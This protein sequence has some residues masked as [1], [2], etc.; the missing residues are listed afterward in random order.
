M[1]GSFNS[2]HKYFIREN[3]NKPL[4]KFLTKRVKDRLLYL[5]LP[6][7][8]AE[9]I[10]QWI[11]YVK[12]VIAFQ[13]REYGEASDEEQERKGIEE[14]NSLLQQLEREKQIDNYVVYDGYL[15]EVILRGYDNSPNQIEFRLNDFITLYNLDFCNK[16]TSPIEYL[17][18]KGELQTAYKFNA[19]N[20]LLQ[21]QQSLGSVSNKFVLFLTVH[22]SY[23]GAELQN[24]IAHPPNNEINSYIQRYNVLNGYEKN[25]R[26][27]RLFF[28]YHIQQQFGAFGFT[29]KILP[30]L[31]YNGL[32]GTTLLHFTVFGIAAANTAAGVPSFQG[33]TEILNQKFISIR[34]SAFIN[35]TI[36]FEGETDVEVNPVT[37]FSNSETF[38]NLWVA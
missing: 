6:S 13:C 37:L 24:F 7:P 8:K 19:I 1:E 3:W 14:L 33:L 38:Q 30:S 29:P 4:L 9:D 2:E 5:G 32:G 26:I 11:E 25:S 12:S 35:K 34:D 10:L 31:L 18:K 16:I 20:K 22:C 27:I 23:D 28:A 17:D 21:I 36:E 15:E